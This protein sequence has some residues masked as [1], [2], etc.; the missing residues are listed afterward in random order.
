VRAVL[1]TA[2]L[3]LAA[4]TSPPAPT[5]PAVLRFTLPPLGPNQQVQAR[6]VE[7]SGPARLIPAQVTLP[8]AASHEYELRIEPGKINPTYDYS[9]EILI[10]EQ[11]QVVRRSPADLLVLTKGRP[12]QVTVTL[13]P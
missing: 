4:C 9:L 2:V 13:Q 6:V 10:L 7:I 1:I 12:S 8:P 3:W 5:A 11:G